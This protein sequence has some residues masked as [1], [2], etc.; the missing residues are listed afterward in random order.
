MVHWRWPG[1]HAGAESEID[2]RG[3]A[4]SHPVRLE[5]VA[6]MARLYFEMEVK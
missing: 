2:Q 5:R 1:G 4:R 3:G 6:A